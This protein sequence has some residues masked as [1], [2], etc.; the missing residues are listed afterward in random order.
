MLLRAALV[1]IAF[2][3]PTNG[4]SAQAIKIVDGDTLKIGDVTYRLNG[5]DAPEAGQKCL[6]EHGKPWSCG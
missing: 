2:A 1:F 5:I 4:S 3:L 6:T